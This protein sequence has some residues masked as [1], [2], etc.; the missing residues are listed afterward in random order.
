MGPGCGG[1]A[2]GGLRVQGE[3]AWEGGATENESVSNMVQLR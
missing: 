1:R 2:I 3:L